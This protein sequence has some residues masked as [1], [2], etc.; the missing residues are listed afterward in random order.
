VAVTFTGTATG[1][2]THGRAFGSDTV[3]GTLGFSGPAGSIAGS[4]AGTDQGSIPYL[5]NSRFNL[6]S[7]DHHQ[8]A[9]L[10][11][12]SET[13]DGLFVGTFQDYHLG[14]TL[15]VWGS[16]G[17]AYDLQNGQ[18]IAALTFST[19]ETIS[20]VNYAVSFSGTV[21]GPGAAGPNGA[22]SVSGTDW[23]T[24]GTQVQAFSLSGANY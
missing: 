12:L 8:G 21:N 6:T 5:V 23:D 14:Q 1:P 7:P 20:G 16:V 3:A 11:V 9:A 13:P 15:T 17:R 24:Y 19:Q 10:T 18:P 4:A 22:T 2:G